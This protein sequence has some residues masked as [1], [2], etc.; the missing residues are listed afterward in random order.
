M[1]RKIK[2]L[3]PK[4]A[5]RLSSSIIKGSKISGSIMVFGFIVYLLLPPMI[6]LHTALDNQP[7]LIHKPVTVKNLK[8]TKPAPVKKSANTPVPVQPQIS[9]PTP[10]P[11]KSVPTVAP[12]PVAVTT[13][14][15][16]P[17]S[18]V[19]SLSPTSTTSTTSTTSPSTSTSTPTTTSTSTT[20]PPATSY[21]STNWS[22][23]LSANSVKYTAVSGRWAVPNPTGNGT[24]TTADA[25]WVGIGGVTTN[26]LIQIGTEDNVTANGTVYSAAFYEILPSA[27]V[28]ITSLSISPGDNISASISETTSNEWAL[29]ITDNTSNQTYTTNLSYNSALSSA[30]WIEED[31]SD[32][33]GNLIPFDNFGTVP[34]SNAYTTANGD[35][36]DLASINADSITMLNSSGQD[37]AVPSA[38]DSS[39]SGFSVTR[40]N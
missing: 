5:Q 40:E 15:P 34:F 13:V 4:K 1:P 31:P 18:S 6:Q 33:N 32:I 10:A 16:T 21:T 7:K 2:V 26:D 19:S 9:V 37:I 36:V 29:V 23:Y 12:T 28:Q 17:S 20:P 25:T 30:E 8:P 22:G 24:S 3:V 14:V 11:I 35:S 39:G 27:S 38:I